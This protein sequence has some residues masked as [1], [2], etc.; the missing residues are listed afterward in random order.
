MEQG[1]L[2]RVEITGERV[3]IGRYTEF[4]TIDLDPDGN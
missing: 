4:N 2:F 1:E 3:T